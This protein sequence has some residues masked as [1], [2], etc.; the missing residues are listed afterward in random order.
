MNI[1]IIAKATEVRPIV[2]RLVAS[3][4]DIEYD[5]DIEAFRVVRFGGARR[6]DREQ[7]DVGE[8]ERPDQEKG[9]THGHEGSPSTLGDGR[10]CA[11]SDPLSD[12]LSGG[13]REPPEAGQHV[14][15]K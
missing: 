10:G 6:R 3:T 2:E 12:P 7:H 1:T 4:A 9:T 11:L 14:A 5:A 13:G 8:E 15:G